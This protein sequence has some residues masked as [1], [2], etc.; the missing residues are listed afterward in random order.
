VAHLQLSSSGPCRG[1][2]G[3]WAER[4]P[5]YG[6]EGGYSKELA[7]G[8]AAIRT[9]LDAFSDAEAAVLENH[10]Y[11]MVD[12]ALRR[13][14]PGWPSRRGRPSIRRTPTGCRRGK[15]EDDVRAALAA[16]R[17]TLVLGRWS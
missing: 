10:G 8:I 1:P 5:R 16:S 9:D 11:L 2:T 17:K 6:F 14:F 4:P 3:G 12:A 15:T 7:S 13:H